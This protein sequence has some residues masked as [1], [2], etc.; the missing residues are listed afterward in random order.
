MARKPIQIQID[1]DKLRV[2]V[3]KLGNN[4]AFGFG[5]WV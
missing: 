1:G 2:E 3:R 5:V 4:Y